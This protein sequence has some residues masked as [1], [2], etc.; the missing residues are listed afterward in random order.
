MFVI[1]NFYD[2]E[3]IQNLAK[4]ELE[5][6]LK[7][8]FEKNKVI[9]SVRRFCSQK[10]FSFLLEAF[11]KVSQRFSDISLVILGEGENEKE[12]KELARKLKIENKVYFLRFQKNPFKFLKNSVIFVSPTLREGFGN[13]LIEAMTC[14]IPTIA[15]R[16]PSGPD[17]IITNRVNG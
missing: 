12:L 10:G 15:T 6:N 7:E 16:C 17:E 1:N 2:L 5:E 14:D 13:V 8:I 9:I 11:S 3:N 4:E